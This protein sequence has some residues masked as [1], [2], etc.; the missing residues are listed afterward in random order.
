[1]LSQGVATSQWLFDEVF[2]RCRGNKMPKVESN[3]EL[4][5]V[6]QGSG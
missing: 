6:F 3:A 4:A 1:M 2:E 5:V